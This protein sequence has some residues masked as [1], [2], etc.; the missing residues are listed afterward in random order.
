MRRLYDLPHLLLILAILFWAGN[1]VLGRAVHT[2]VPPVGLAFWRWTVAFLIILGP[3]WK[4]LRRDAPELVGHWR[5]LLV[6]SFSG[7]AVFN[8]FVYTGLNDTEALNAFLIQS[9]MP[10]VIVVMSFLFFRERI[11]GRQSLG[12][13]VSLVG[14]TVILTRGNLGLLA[15]LEPNPG[16]LWVLAAVVFYAAYSALLRKRPEIH[17]LSFLAVIFAG[18]TVMLAPFYAAETIGGRPVPLDT[19]SLATIAY[20]AVFPSILSYVCFNR[21]VELLGANKAGLFIHLMPVFGSLMSMALLGESF[22]AFHGLGIAF[23]IT[24]ILLA[25]VSR[26]RP[27]SGPA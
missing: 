25:T 5:I 24:G 19:T 14:V 7:I 2:E 15:T 21:G 12:V 3:A 11:T 23:I 16:D 17:P 20:V 22:R 26:P 18:G 27:A 6:L 8:T 10:V 9:F 13:L 1:F 4:H